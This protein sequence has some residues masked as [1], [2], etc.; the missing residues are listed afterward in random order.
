MGSTQ[1]C[2][3]IITP[4]SEHKNHSWED[5]VEHMECQGSNPDWPHR[6]QASYG[7]FIHVIWHCNFKNEQFLLLTSYSSICDVNTRRNREAD[8]PNSKLNSK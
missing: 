5:M 2:S 3:E 6:R 4:G 7:H 1:R 8:S